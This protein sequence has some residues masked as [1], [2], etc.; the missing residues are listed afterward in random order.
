MNEPEASGQALVERL[1]EALIEIRDAKAVW[2]DAGSYAGGETWCGFARRLQHLAAD[3]LSTESPAPA[4]PPAPAN[5][6]EMTV[7]RMESFNRRARQEATLLSNLEGILH[8]SDFLLQAEKQF[9]AAMA[10][11][12]VAGGT[13]AASPPLVSDCAICGGLVTFDGKEGDRIKPNC[14]GGRLGREK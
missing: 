8:G 13:D 11:A 9:A 7:A 5:E 4:S 10:G 2:Q 6:L 1:Q 12:Y 14:W 3:A